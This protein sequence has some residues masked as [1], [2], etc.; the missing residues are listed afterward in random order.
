MSTIAVTGAGSALGRRVV[1]ALERRPDVGR[2]I[3]LDRSAARVLSD[4]PSAPQPADLADLA[5]LDGPELVEALA[6]VDVVVHLVDDHGRTR[7]SERARGGAGGIGALARTRHV[8]TAARAAGVGRA[9]VVSSV[10]AY[11]A[12]PDNDL[13]LTEESRLRGI[14]AFGLAEHARDVERWLTVWLDDEP[15]A[16]LQVAVLRLALLLG[17]G[18][19]SFLTRA[20]EAPR[21]PAVKGHRPPLQFLHP[22]DA[23]AAVVHTV[24]HG[25]TGAYNV[26][27]EGWLSFDEVTAIVGRRV[28]EVPEELAYRS[29]ERLWT[30]GLGDQP[31]GII[32]LFSYPCVMSCERL[33]DTG[34]QPQHTNRDAVASMATEHARYLTLGPVR[35]RRSTARWAAFGSFLLAVGTVLGA[36][37]ILRRAWRRRRSGAPL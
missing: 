13:P 25:L 18:V 12:H 14:E 3:V 36:V 28:V 4:R 16:G 29:V 5:D 6:G 26:A 20:F 17:P 23:A 22:D 33:L 34:W 37:R 11:G 19:D 1:A 31:P 15:G 32:E 7:R 35:T 30:L 10:L 2:A 24:E 21:I 27:A 8:M 9:V